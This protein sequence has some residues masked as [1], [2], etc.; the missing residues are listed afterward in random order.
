MPKHYKLA[1]VVEQRLLPWSER[2]IRRM[3]AA[4]ELRVL[5][6]GRGELAR[7][8]ITDTEIARVLRKVPNAVPERQAFKKG[9]LETK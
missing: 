1:E 2:T 6:V 8:V 5:N 3:I 9:D 7:Y 4:G